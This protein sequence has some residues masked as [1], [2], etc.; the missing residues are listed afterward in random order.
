MV[1][2]KRM[3]RVWGV[4]AGLLAAA[5]VTAAEPER[6]FVV[7]NEAVGVPVFPH[8]FPDRPYEVLGQIK[9]GVRK[10]NMFAPE[11]SQAK[12]YKELWERARRLGAD[13]VIDARYGDPRATAISDGQTDATGTAIRFRQGR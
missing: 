10:A 6:A 2:G 11:P 9:A 8:G 4:V 13:A 1:G 7:I 5:A 3:A 12:I